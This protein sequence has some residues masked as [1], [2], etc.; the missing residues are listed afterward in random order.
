MQKEA[1]LLGRPCLTLRDTTEWTETLKGGAN[2]L[3]GAKAA[4][5]VRGVRAVEK[6]PPEVKPGTIYGDGRTAE[7]IAR[8]IKAFLD[9]RSRAGR[10]D[11]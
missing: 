4:T 9:R 5:I 7:R 11:T 10:L 8:A 6:T 3:V 2:R 1:F